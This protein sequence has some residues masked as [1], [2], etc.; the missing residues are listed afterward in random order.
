MLAAA[1]LLAPLIACFAPLGLAPLLAASGGATVLIQAAG[2]DWRLP[3]A[4]AVLPAA[5]LAAW[6]L[7][8]ALWAIDPAMALDRAG[9]FA[10]EVAAGAMLVAGAAGLGPGA[11]RRVGGALASGVATAGV[12]LVFESLSSGALW[13]LLSEAFG[14]DPYGPVRYNRSATTLA[15]FGWPAALALW[16]RGGGGRVAGAALALLVIAAVA[17]HYSA[18]AKAAI[19]VAIAAGGLAL[20]LPRRVIAGVVGASL[21]VGVLTAPVVSSLLPSYRDLDGRLAVGASLGHRLDIWRFTA[22]RIAERP[23]AGWGM[24]A[25]RD[26]PGGQAP[27]WVVPGDPASG[28][29][30]TVAPLMPLH[31]HNGSLQVWLELGLVGAV[32]FAALLCVAVAGV[33]RLPA[34]APAAAAWATLAAGVTIAHS[35]YG[36]W[37][38]WWVACLWLAAVWVVAVAGAPQR[39]G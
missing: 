17:G 5:L 25:S 30:E 18:T 8:S 7:T 10:F 4:W 34:G 21:A 22:E 11:R 6:A 15:L 13:A 20:L 16:L 33:A 1:S 19:P 32:L 26:I 39:D 24:E 14:L 2:R 29:G 31:P 28:V 37:Q 27:A 3:H 35:S 9:R 12:V 36:V 23:V 38:S